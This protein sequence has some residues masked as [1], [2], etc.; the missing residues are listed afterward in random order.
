MGHSVS[1]FLLLPSGRQP[2]RESTPNV[3]TPD[4]DPL[5]DAPLLRP[6]SPRPGALRPRGVELQW[7]A[8]GVVSPPPAALVRVCRRRAASL[9]TGG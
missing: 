4:G 2:P 6:L 5:G 1:Y 8:P 7:S 9:D 3:L